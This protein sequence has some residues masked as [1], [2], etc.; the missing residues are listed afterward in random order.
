[1]AIGGAMSAFLRIFKNLFSCV[2]AQTALRKKGYSWNPPHD[3]RQDNDGKLTMLFKGILGQ[4]I[5]T[6]KQVVSTVK[7]HTN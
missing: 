1:M 5:I 2:F 6:V 4:L 7:H 3:E